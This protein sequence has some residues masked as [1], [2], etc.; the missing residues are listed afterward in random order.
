MKTKQ[1]EM[2]AAMAQMEET[3][4]PIGRVVNLTPHAIMYRV[5]EGRD[6]TFP[7]AGTVA[8]VAMVD[9][10]A[11]RD[12]YDYGFCGAGDGGQDFAFRV[13]TQTPGPVEGLPDP[14]SGTLFIVSRMVLDAIRG[15]RRDVV[16]PDT[17]T[18]AMRDA[19]GRILGVTRFV[20]GGGRP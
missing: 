9:T 13:V 12:L 15:N 20:A 11:E 8:R 2:R 3:T 17:G 10:P 7:A 5:G 6:I 18:T 1:D 16:A 19:Q 14:E 4:G